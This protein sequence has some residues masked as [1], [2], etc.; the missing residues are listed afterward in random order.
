MHFDQA[1]SANCF[2]E[3]ELANPQTDAASKKTKKK[4]WEETRGTLKHQE[5]N[6]I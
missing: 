6:K 3:D 5:L 4:I 1:I 2:S